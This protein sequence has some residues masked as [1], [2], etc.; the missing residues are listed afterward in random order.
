MEIY[1]ARVRAGLD[2]K[3][4]PY[5][6]FD[7]SF[8][9]FYS[10]EDFAEHY[11]HSRAT[12]VTLPQLAVE[13]DAGL[14]GPTGIHPGYSKQVSERVIR[15]RYKLLARQV[16]YTLPRLIGDAQFVDAVR[17]LRQE[18]WKD[19]HLLQAIAHIRLNYLVNTGI[20]GTVGDKMFSNAKEIYERDETESDGLVPNEMFTIAK[21]KF[22]LRLSQ[23]STLK[24]LGF[25][26]HQRAPNFDSVNRFLNR[27]NYWTDDVPHDNI[28]PD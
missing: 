28:L 3:L 6:P 12:S 15:K 26:C 1:E 25:E 5:A 13:T 9:Q 19:W 21:L 24:G 23:L 4:T 2:A 22:A 10:R 14:A 16:I 20:T 18:G 8:R 11:L 27:F 17:K 7:H